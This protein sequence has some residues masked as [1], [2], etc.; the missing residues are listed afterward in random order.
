LEIEVKKKEKL[1]KIPIVS[2]KVMIQMIMS[3]AKAITE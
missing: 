1:N 3:S 2:K